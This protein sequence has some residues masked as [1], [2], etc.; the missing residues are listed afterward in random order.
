MDPDS[1]NSG[2]CGDGTD[3]HAEKLMEDE[4]EDSDS[5]S[6]ST[7]SKSSSS[8]IEVHL[9]I[10]PSPNP[11]TYHEIDDLDRST[12]I[13]TVPADHRASTTA[14]AASST[15]SSVS[16]TNSAAASS[17][18]G[19]VDNTRT[20]Y[21]FKFNSILE[22]STSQA[23]VFQNIGAPAIRNALEGYNSTVFAYGQ[24]NSGKT[25]TITGGPE[26]YEDRGIIPRAITMLFE[27]F[28]KRRDTT[29]AT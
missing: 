6:P 29:G 17:K 1:A 21:A 4:G 5:P 18:G 2:C 8:S 3:G 23:T 16:V 20:R 13:F 14:A 24:T 22:P 19:Y 28:A 12:L 9:R 25:F 15:T 10:R 27:E 7:P 26:R 11:S